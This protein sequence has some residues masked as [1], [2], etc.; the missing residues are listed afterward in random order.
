LAFQAQE[1]TMMAA[2]MA[3]T[4]IQLPQVQLLGTSSVRTL[5]PVLQPSG[6]Q[7][8]SQPPL[9]LPAQSQPFST[10]QHQVS[11]GATSSGFE[12]T[13][14][15]TPLRSGFTPQSAISSQLVLDSS[16]GQDISF[17][18]SALTGQ[19]TPPPLQAPQPLLCP[20]PLQS[21]CH[22]Q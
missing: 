5:T 21:G 4:G 7:S 14:Q 15:F 12:Q 9:Q 3:A 18:Y 2:L 8:Q 1:T 16:A 10:L 6:L 19:P 11:Q 13:L 20:S 17:S 22:R